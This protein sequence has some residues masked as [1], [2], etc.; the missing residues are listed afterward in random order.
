MLQLSHDPREAERQMHAVIYYLTAFGYIDGEFDPSERQTVRDQIGRLVEGRVQLAL[1]G[2]TKPGLREELI[3]R[4]THHFHE[5]FVE[6]DDSIRQLLDEP[7]AEGEASS[8]FVLARLKLR[9]YEL[10]TGFDEDNR[11]ALLSS[12]DEIMHADGVVDPREQAFRDE[13]AALLAAPMELGEHELEPIITGE[14]VI[15]PALSLEPRQSNHPFFEPSE[16]HYPRDP[17]AFAESA[18]NDLS[19]IQATLAGLEHERSTGNGRLGAAQD[20]G[21]FAGAD[22]FLDGHVYVLPPAPG[23]AYELLVLGDLH[24]CY[25]CLKAALMQA[26]FFGKVRA[27]RDDPRRNPDVK[28]VLLGDYIDRGKFS[29]NGVL[30]TVMQLYTALPGHVFPL[31]GNHEYYVELNGRVYGAVRPSEALND[32]VGIAPNEVFAAFMRLFESLPNMLIFDRTLFVHA[33][34]PRDETLAA[35]WSGLASLNDAE[36]RFQMLWS[37]PSSA[38]YVPPELQRANARFPFGRKQFKSFLG[39]LGCTTMVRGHEKVVEGFRCVYD[40]PGST[41]INVFSAG[42][43]HNRDLPEN[44]SYRDVVPMALSIKH[45]DG[46]SE[47]TPFAIDYERYNDPAYNAF[48]RT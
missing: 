25:S 33:G 20:V 30:R 23:K 6:V 7:V 43:R 14:V 44:S 41:L 17:G 2:E 42:G 45:R 46:V 21:E 13:L 9:C 19:L 5:V 15:G 48:F 16:W 47:L 32:L 12:V 18:T 28:L 37:D 22:P 39:R 1:D 29:Y 24:G 26:D 4:W 35:K 3:G 11:A 38:D 34:I 40:E 36:I 31:R 8:A 27:Y 10:F